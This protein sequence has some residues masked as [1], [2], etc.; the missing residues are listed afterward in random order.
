MYIYLHRQKNIAQRLW[1]V[2]CRH[3]DDVYGITMGIALPDT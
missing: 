2:C 3:R 1:I